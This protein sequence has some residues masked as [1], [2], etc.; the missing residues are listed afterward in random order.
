MSRLGRLHG[1]A[2]LAQAPARARPE[3]RWGPTRPADALGPP[4]SRRRIVGRRVAAPTDRSVGSDDD[5]V[6]TFLGAVTEVAATL[7]SGAPPAVAW[8]RGLGVRVVDGV[9][10][11]SDL[12]SLW[13]DDVAAAR[14]V[15]TVSR[16]SAELGAAPSA[17]LDEVA[18]GL[19]R[20]AQARAE[21]RAALAGPQSTARILAWLPL[22]GM[23]LGVALG[24]DPFTVLLDGG[25]GTAL[26]VAGALLTWGG[27][28]WTRR[29]LRVAEDAGR[30][31]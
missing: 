27:R 23:L 7:R 15:H 17:L 1:A 9:P 14:A 10:L 29:Y 22:L 6:S 11:W 20:Q 8:R 25:S 21:R 16:L 18:A 3:A 12:V 13:P 26:L 30:E 28:R 31:G 19:G 2:V 4:S 5:A 24:A